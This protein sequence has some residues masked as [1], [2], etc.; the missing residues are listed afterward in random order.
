MDKSLSTLKKQFLLFG[1]EHIKYEDI[2][3]R[4]SLSLLLFLE[5]KNK[6]SEKVRE[7][8]SSF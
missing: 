6:Q 8:N 2:L 5:N 7:K 3:L 4:E 1:C